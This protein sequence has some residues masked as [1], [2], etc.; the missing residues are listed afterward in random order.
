MEWN[1]LPKT[2]ADARATGSTYYYSGKICKHGH[3]S[4]RITANAVCY[5]CHAIMNS[6]TQR[7]VRNAKP[8]KVSLRQQAKDEGKNTYETGRPCKKG[9]NTYRYT[10]TGN[11]STCHKAAS[12][13]TY[14]RKKNNFICFRIQ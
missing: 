14:K 11:C 9:H 12:A 1:K 10:A 6:A 7:K 2:L 4:H 13:A 3:N 8:R 5:E